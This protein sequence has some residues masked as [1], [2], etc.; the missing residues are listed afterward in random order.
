MTWSE[1]PRVHKVRSSVRTSSRA[2]ICLPVGTVLTDV[3]AACA[4]RGTDYGLCC[5]VLFDHLP[6]GFASGSF[7]A[8][9]R[10]DLA[11]LRD[12]EDDLAHGTNSE[13]PM[14]QRGTHRRRA[15]DRRCPTRATST[16]SHLST[17]QSGKRGNSVSGSQ[18]LARKLAKGSPRDEDRIMP[19]NAD[20]GSNGQPSEALPGNFHALFRE[21]SIG[22]AVQTHGCDPQP[23]LQNSAC[24]PRYVRR[25]ATK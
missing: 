15:P 14:T 18:A 24:R 6:H 19:Q 16:G 3:A 13:L 4:I 2:I 5:A 1:S 8:L 22:D 7:R 21:L 9:C 20:K 12:T 23:E 11:V 17:G 25:A 10:F